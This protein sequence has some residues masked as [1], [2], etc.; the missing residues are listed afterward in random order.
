MNKMN[1]TIIIISALIF[2]AKLG[3]FKGLIY[4]GLMLV[5]AVCFT[6]IGSI[7]AQDILKKLKVKD[8]VIM[9]IKK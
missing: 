5:A 9:K 7:L 2:I 3:T 8:I 4:T 1:M 6:L